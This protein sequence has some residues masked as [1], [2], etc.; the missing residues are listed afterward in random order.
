MR[1]ISSLLF[2][3]VLLTV[4]CK[5]PGANVAPAQVEDTA[6]APACA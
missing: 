6:V 2:I 3:G 1:I 5:D 4:G